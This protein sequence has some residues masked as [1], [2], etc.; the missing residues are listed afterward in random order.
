MKPRSGTLLDQPF[1]SFF[2]GYK[3]ATEA[4]YGKN[5]LPNPWDLLDML[6]SSEDGTPEYVPGASIAVPE[7]VMLG[8]RLNHQENWDVIQTPYGTGKERNDL[9]S[10]DTIWQVRQADGTYDTSSTKN[11]L[12]KANP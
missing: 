9:F 1:K 11:P 12:E 6:P 8:R 3:W 10:W 7:S 4:W 5:D 2:A